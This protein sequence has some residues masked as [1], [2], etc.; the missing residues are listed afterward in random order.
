MPPPGTSRGFLFDLSESLVFDNSSDKNATEPHHLGAIWGGA[1]WEV[2]MKIGR[3]KADQ[4]VFGT[5]K[6]LKPSPQEL[7]KPAYYVEQLLATNTALGLEID[8]KVIREA[9]ARRKLN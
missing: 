2:R 9:F 5:W 1:F 7:N 6:R 3:E 4:L 8:A